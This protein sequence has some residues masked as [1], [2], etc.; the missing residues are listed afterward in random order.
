MNDRLKIILEACLRVH[1]SDFTLKNRYTENVYARACFY[2]LA[3]NDTITL[4]K[5]GRICGGRDHATVLHGLRKVGKKDGEYMLVSGFRNMLERFEREV[6]SIKSLKTEEEST[7]Y[8]KSL[9]NKIDSLEEENTKL[10]QRLYYN[11][12][13]KPKPEE[14]KINYKD[15]LYMTLKS[16]PE[17]LLREFKETR[18]T[19]YLR[20]N[21]HLFNNPAAS[22]N[23]E[24][25]EI[26]PN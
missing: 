21:K 22:I 8:Y 6:M 18:L 14:V 17:S 15:S 4:G 10:R 16:L 20:M 3:K 5:V 1:G 13:N 26:I 25:E 9:L 2:Y 12:K 23:V 11:N 7:I 19:P 24:F